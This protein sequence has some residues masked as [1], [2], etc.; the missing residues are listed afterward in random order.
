MR[1]TD[2]FSTARK[3]SYENSKIS[4]PKKFAFKNNESCLQ[5]KSNSE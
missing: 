5:R 3:V 2:I 1:T 4:Y